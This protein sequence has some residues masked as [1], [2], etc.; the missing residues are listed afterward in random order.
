M[1]DG[2]DD[3][4][5]FSAGT[6]SRQITSNRLIDL[7]QAG[8]LIDDMELV[9]IYQLMVTSSQFSDSLVMVVH[10]SDMAVTVAISRIMVTF[11]AKQ[12]ILTVPATSLEVGRPDAVD[13]IAGPD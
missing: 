1:D 5:L 6:P 11:K 7:N 10:Y 2:I 13:S 3:P 4:L 12:D 9:L 8:S